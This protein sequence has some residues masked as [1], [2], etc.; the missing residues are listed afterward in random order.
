MGILDTIKSGIQGH[1]DK[2]KEDREFEERLRKEATIQKRIIYEE[3]YKKNA[4]VVA[5][6][7]AYKE[8]AQKSGLQRL[9]AKDRAL[10][11]SERNLEPG[12]FFD[13]MRDLTQRNKAR[14][15]ANLKRTAEMREEANKMRQ[16]RSIGSP[17]TNKPFKQT[18]Y[19]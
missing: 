1:F 2:K 12:T 19:G 16:E 5:K 8:A 14:T 10:R 15:E 4:L 11:L 17:Q 6:A 18:Y 13:K 3:E 7:K 9:R